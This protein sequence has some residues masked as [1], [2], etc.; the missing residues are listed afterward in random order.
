[1]PCW[2]STNGEMIVMRM[3]RDA[4]ELPVS[5]LPAR[6]IFCG[7]LLTVSQGIHCRSA[8]QEHPSALPDSISSK[9]EWNY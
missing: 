5:S 8:A 3:S 7:H 2:R 1:V 4:P 6:L 9:L